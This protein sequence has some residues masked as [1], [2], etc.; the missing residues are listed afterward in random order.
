MNWVYIDLDNTICTH[1]HYL[2][3]LNN[4]SGFLVQKMYLKTKP[5]EG[6]KTLRDKGEKNRKALK[7]SDLKNLGEYLE[8]NNKH[9]LLACYLLYYTLI[10]PKEM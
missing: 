8:K 9:Y 6:L 4:F 10:R 7:K 1:N 5:T 2:V 3:W